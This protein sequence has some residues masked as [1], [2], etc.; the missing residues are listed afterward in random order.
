MMPSESAMYL[1][2]K[3]GRTP[4]LFLLIFEPHFERPLTSLETGDRNP[5]CQSAKDAF[6]LFGFSLLTENLACLG[7]R[8]KRPSTGRRH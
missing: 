6:C 5:K 1:R 7:D 2:S 4:G 3:R 8:V